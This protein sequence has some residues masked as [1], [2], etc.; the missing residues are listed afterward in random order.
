ML[1]KAEI[2]KQFLEK[3]LRLTEEEVKGFS[4][5]IAST[6]ITNFRF[7]KNQLIHVFLPIKRQ[8][9]INTWPIIHHLWR[10]GVRVVVSK[11][12]FVQ[13]SMSHFLLTPKTKVVENKLGIPEPIDG[14]L[15]DVL[16]IN[17]VLVPLLAFDTNGCRVGYG[18]G[19]Y[20]KFLNECNV[21]V[22][23]VGLSIFP[24]VDQIDNEAH[25]VTLDACITPDEMY[26]F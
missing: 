23:K 19:F 22:N 18:K 4:D 13:V 9:E 24:P 12:D 7:G 26:R 3:R 15:I 25:D 16:S 6:F 5:S 2:R 1:T 20:D 10:Y 17:T 11:S 14:E 8:N 21:S